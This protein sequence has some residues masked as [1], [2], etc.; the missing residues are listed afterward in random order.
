L[1]TI[2]MLKFNGSFMYFIFASSVILLKNVPVPEFPRNDFPC[3]GNPPDQASRNL[4]R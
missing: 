4:I 1:L 3:S 2:I